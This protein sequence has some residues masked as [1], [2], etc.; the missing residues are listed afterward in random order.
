[1]AERSG[2]SAR[3]AASATALN[4]DHEPDPIV[5]WEDAAVDPMR[6]GDYLREFQALVDRYGYE[7][8]IY[9]HFGDG[10]VPCRITFDLRA[11]RA[12]PSGAASSEEAADLVVSYGG[13]LSGEHGDGQAKAEFLP[14]PCSAPS[15]CRRSA[16]SRRSGTRKG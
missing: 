15:S 9:G 13:S 16:S 11:P 7:T 4:L 14:K 12:S 5:G 2:P 1:V 8:S 3:P 6:L 10:C